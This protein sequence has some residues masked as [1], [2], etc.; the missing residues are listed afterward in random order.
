MSEKPVKDSPLSTSGN[1][2]LARDHLANERTFLAWVRTG[3]AVVVF[4]FAIGRFAVAIRQWMQLEGQGH[5]VPT[6]G[7]S[8]WFGTAAIIAGVLVCLMGLVRYRQTRK[9][10]DSGN[11]QPAGFLIDL[12]GVVT[13][14]FGL[15]LAAYLIY[16]DLHF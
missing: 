4:G 16:I 3:V 11:F 10:I 14:L 15:A 5:V 6:S 9:Q 7:L 2:N 8:V 13:A 12:V 1:A